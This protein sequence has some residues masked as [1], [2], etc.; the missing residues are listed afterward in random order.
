MGKLVKHM[1]C[2]VRFV[3]QAQVYD[4]A[5]ILLGEFV[6]SLVL[7]RRNKNLKQWTDQC[8]SPM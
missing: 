8:Y 7:S 5:V 3:M 2:L 6:M 1:G 4:S